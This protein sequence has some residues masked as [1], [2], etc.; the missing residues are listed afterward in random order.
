MPWIGCSK[1]MQEQPSF[2][3]QEAPRKHSPPG[4]VPRDS[5]KI[6]QAPLV[7]T[8]QRLKQGERLF[9]INCTHCHGIH[10]EGD[11]PVAGYLKELPANLHHARVKGKSEN[12]LYDILTH[13]KDAMPPFKGELSVEERWAIVEFVK[14]LSTDQTR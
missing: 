8:E 3:A 13:G 2:Q 4:S 11:G 12:D 7:K 9:A 14:S 5:R 10:G 6:L 1:D